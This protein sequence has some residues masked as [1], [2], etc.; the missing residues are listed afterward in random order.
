VNFPL[1][2]MQCRNLI[3]VA[4][5]FG[6]V[7]PLGSA[8]AQSPPESGLYRIQ[9]GT[10]IEC[11]G[12]SGTD[13][14]YPLPNQDQTYVKLVR[15]AQ[16]GTTTMTFLAADQRTVFT[17]VP[18]PP[19]GAIEFSFPYGFGYGN[20]L[21]F[22]VDPGPPYAKYWTYT[23]SNSFRALRLEGNLGTL[24]AG[25]ADTPTQFSHS[26]IV[27]VLIPAPKLSLLGFSTGRGAQLFIQGDAGDTNVIEASRDLI[28]W[29]PVNTNVMGYSL[30]PI[31]PYFIFED[32][33]STNL[34]H[35]FYR[36][37]KLY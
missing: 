24:Q 25:C 1:E 12:F 31:C 23:V 17:T 18:C 3:A 21:V 29:I 11:C 33:D 37:Y 8:F 34:E 15:D 22:H 19:A 14:V 2:F 5:V 16:S 4:F 10:Y 30:C 35:R 26:N 9:S 7:I 6:S 28:N 13:T 27:A 36:V 32:S 20:S